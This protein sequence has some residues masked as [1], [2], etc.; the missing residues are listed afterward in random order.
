MAE[1]TCSLYDFAEKPISRVDRLASISPGNQGEKP[2]HQEHI[3][4]RDG[5]ELS[6]FRFSVGLNPINTH[7]T[8]LRISGGNLCVGV[9]G[10]H[11]AAGA[12]D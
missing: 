1:N 2:L 7:G 3:V 12:R 5:I 9:V 4:A 10:V 8:V 11:W 6:T